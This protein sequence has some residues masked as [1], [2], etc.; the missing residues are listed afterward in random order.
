MFICSRTA[1]LLEIRTELWR[2]L[3]P[4]NPSQL[5]VSSG[6]R[7]LLGAAVVGS[8]AAF[9][10]REEREAPSPTLLGPDE[11]ISHFKDCHKLVVGAATWDEPYF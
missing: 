11:E 7:E 5:F 4:A 1:V 2:T 10:L 6:E 8:G 3:H 9:K